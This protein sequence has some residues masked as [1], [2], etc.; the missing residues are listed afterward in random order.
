MNAS[1]STIE[2][3]ARCL[4]CDT[5]IAA[6]QPS[7]RTG[8]GVFCVDCFA[9]LKQQVQQA[10]AAQSEGIDFPR[11]VLGA[12]LGGIGGATLWWAGTVL[13]KVNFGLIA[14]VIGVAVGRGI[15][16]MTGGKRAQSLQILS[17]AVAVLAYVAG[18]YLT[19]RTFILRYLE[20]HGKTANLPLI[21]PDLA[22]FYQVT[23]VGFRAFDLIFL[24]IVVHQAWKIPAPLRLPA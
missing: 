14:V 24:A 16:T 6:G 4:E 18:V 9:R 5:T 10:I 19:N 22:T 21:P 1:M 15:L 7:V 12:L 23:S 20:E 13:T 3:E 8:R 17:V 11:A 2:G